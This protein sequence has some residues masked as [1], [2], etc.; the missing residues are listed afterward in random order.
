[1]PRPNLTQDEVDGFRD[2]AA[3]TALEMVEDDGVDSLTLRALAARL[4]CSYA[5]P[6]R[7]FR[8]K[9]QL[10]DAVRKLAFDL[11]GEFMAAELEAYD[12]ESGRP[13]ADLYLRFVFEH[14]E[15]FR[16][17][18]EMKQEVISPETREAQARAWKICSQPFRDAVANGS[19]VGDP[20]LIAH[21]AWAALHGL[22]TLS[23]A[24]QLYLGKDVG[25]IAIGLGAVIDG[26]RPGTV[27]RAQ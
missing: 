26:F 27:S 11:L 16:V 18:F 25:E 9:A 5:K 2:F 15:A 19:L 24:D 1:M 13:M 17:M 3:A 6:Y 20:E 21:V 8:D 22:A 12:P 10:V 23:L 14:P 4:G 7:Y